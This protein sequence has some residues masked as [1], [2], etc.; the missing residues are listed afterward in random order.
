[1]TRLYL[2]AL[3]GI[4]LLAPGG[5]AQ[6]RYQSSSGNTHSSGATTIHPITPEQQ[7]QQQQAT[8]QHQNPH[9]PQHQQIHLA[10]RSYSPAGAAKEGTGGDRTGS[11]VD[12]VSTVTT[13]TGITVEV[14]LKRDTRLGYSSGG[15]Q[16][17]TLGQNGEKR[18]YSFTVDRLT[19]LVLTADSERIAIGNPTSQPCNASSASSSAATACP[20]CPSWACGGRADVRQ[21]CSVAGLCVCNCGLVVSELKVEVAKPSNVLLTFRLTDLMGHPVP[22]LDPQDVHLFY[23]PDPFV[24]GAR[25]ERLDP[26]ESMLPVHGVRDVL[27]LNL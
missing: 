7:Q 10:T 24:K 23:A 5:L 11:V 25:L 26:R 12:S 18:S 19:D 16:A 17:V 21:V 4:T 2:L 13:A 6:Y 1:M 8:S 9:P 22:H 3:A 27:F 14:T 15:K 20:L